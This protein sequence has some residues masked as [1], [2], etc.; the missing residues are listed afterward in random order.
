M[1]TDAGRSPPGPPVAAVG[2]VSLQCQTPVQKNGGPVSID[3]AMTGAAN[4]RA[5]PP[6][7]FAAPLEGSMQINEGGVTVD[8][9]AEAVMTRR[10][11]YLI[12]PADAGMFVI[13]PLA[14]AVL[15]PLGL[16]RRL[17]GEQ[18][19]LLVEAAD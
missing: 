15:T 4:L 12:F 11:R 5:A 10:W 8:R 16:R 13:P 9:R 17:R 19:A 14:T 6:P 1:A 3:V 18:R 2:E 7:A